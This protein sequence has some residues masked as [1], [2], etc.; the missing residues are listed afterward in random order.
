[1]RRLISRSWLES[2]GVYGYRRITRELRELGEGCGKHRVARLM[3]QIGLQSAIGYLRHPGKDGK[4]PIQPPA[5]HQWH[6]L[7]VSQPNMVWM[8]EVTYIRT[9]QGKLF[10]AT[11]SDVFSRKVVGWSA[12]AAMS[13]ELVLKALA[14]A[15][16]RRE[17]APG[18]LVNFGQGSQ[19]SR[20]DLRLFLRAFRLKAYISRR[21]DR[22]RN[23]I[24]DG[25]SQ[26]LQ[27]E[28]VRRKIYRTFE[29]AR[30][31]VSDYVETFYNPMRRHRHTGGLSPD[32]YERRH[33]E[34]LNGLP[35]RHDASHL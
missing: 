9:Y 33:F 15:V 16:L 11:V 3:G 22:H 32:E 31:E 29:E 21:K 12:E 10:V 14:M 34:K 17:P 19:F 5:Y 1:M 25:F 7:S 24:A 8:I 4:R 2:G 6:E 18:V 13:P 28:R 23:G 20:H 30:R 35:R 26:Y 27:R